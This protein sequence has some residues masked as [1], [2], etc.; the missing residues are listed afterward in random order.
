MIVF[1]KGNFSY[2]IHVPQLNHNP[3]CVCMYIMYVC[4]IYGIIIGK[5]NIWQ[6]A[7]NAI[8][9]IS[10]WQYELSNLITNLVLFEMLR[11]R[12]ATPTFAC[13]PCAQFN[14]AKMLI[15]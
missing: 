10:I 5:S 2:E 12:K 4:T 1:H 8:G 15:T 11:Y 6:L 3:V 9:V 13:T 14:R 7:Q